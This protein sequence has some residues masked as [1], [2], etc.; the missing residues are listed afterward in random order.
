[1]TLQEI[2]LTLPNR[3]GVLAGA[4]KVLAES[5]INLAALSVTSDGEKG[6]VRLI[7]NDP[8]RALAALK[9]A[10]YKAASH[11]LL[12]VHLEDRAG[13]FLR[14]LELLAEAEINVQSVAI[15]VTREGA[16]SLVAVSVDSS[17]L[18]KGRA[19]LAGSGY[20]SESAERLVTNADLL[21]TP[22]GIPSESVGLLM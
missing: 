21:A 12:V 5:Q 22:P 16:Q 3:P 14:I 20:I 4:A 18:K 10:H 11:E 19:I 2:A 8:K 7:V 17:D 13:S 1:M 15:L 9:A 6:Q